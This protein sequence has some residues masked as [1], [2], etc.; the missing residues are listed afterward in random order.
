MEKQN[1]RKRKKVEYNAVKCHL[2]QGLQPL[3]GPWV[4]LVYINAPLEFPYGNFGQVNSFL[5]LILPIKKELQYY[6]NSG[7]C[8]QSFREMQNKFPRDP[9]VLVNV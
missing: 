8:N 6:P 4:T 7:R 5:C 3:P 2:V 9:I 1:K